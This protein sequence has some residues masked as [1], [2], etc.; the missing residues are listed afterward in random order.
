M[1]GESGVA[2]ELGKL[3]YSHGLSSRGGDSDF[4][5]FFCW[6]DVE[7]ACARGGPT[8]VWE[9]FGTGRKTHPW[10]PAQNASLHFELPNA[11]QTW[12]DPPPNDR[13]DLFL[14]PLRF[15]TRHSVVGREVPRRAR[16]AGWI[17]WVSV[18]HVKM[19]GCILSSARWT[20]LTRVPEQP[21]EERPR[22]RPRKR[23]NGFGN[24]ATQKKRNGEGPY[25]PR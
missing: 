5:L 19:Q 3:S 18:G 4:W 6:A 23:T 25:R 20:G 8:H 7:C 13:H 17:A 22:H 12:I 21:N 1:R 14:F 9:S 2:H 24:K 11:S 16:G 10:E 15:F